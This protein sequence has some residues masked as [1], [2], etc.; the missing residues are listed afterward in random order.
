MD[1]GPWSK[2]SWSAVLQDPPAGAGP[3]PRRLRNIFTGRN[4]PPFFELHGLKSE[5]EAAAAA[6]FVSL[7]M[8]LRCKG[9]GAA[10]RPLGGQCGLATWQGPARGHGGRE[11]ALPEAGERAWARVAWRTWRPAS[12]ARVQHLLSI[13]PPLLPA[14]PAVQCARCRAASGTCRRCGC[15]SSRS[16]CARCGAT[17]WRTSPRRV[18]IRRKARRAAPALLRGR[19]PASAEKG[20]PS[21][22]WAV[23]ERRSGAARAC[24][25]SLARL[26]G[27]RPVRWHGHQTTL[28]A[29][30]PLQ[31]AELKEGG[32]LKNTHKRAAE[33]AQGEPAPSK[34]QRTASAAPAAPQRKGA[35]AGSQRTKASAAGRQ[36]AA[37]KRRAV[38]SQ[39]QRAIPKQ[40][41][42]CSTLL[43]PRWLIKVHA[44]QA[45]KMQAKRKQ[46]EQQMRQQQR[47][48]VPT[49]RQ[50]VEELRRQEKEELDAGLRRM[51][52]A[53]ARRS[54]AARQQRQR[55]EAAA[56]AA[57]KRQAEQKRQAKQEL[58]RERAKRRARRAIGK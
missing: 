48:S 16:R 20:A 33:P 50:R 9:R 28:A 7:W 3:P 34:K 15:G 22:P 27:P 49:K 57:R 56:V 32:Q 1:V 55:E 44:Q 31:V 14:R 6:D 45:K 38:A 41:R 8:R 2:P 23:F 52:E 18:Y 25:R 37:P 19:G 21:T 51:A 13:R 35:A 39:P 36:T 54:A 47:L 5:L 17:S 10:Q 11:G 42:Q 29:P 26:Q 30:C 58:G 43:P 46:Q 53:Q 12:Q 24:R 40:Q 4:D